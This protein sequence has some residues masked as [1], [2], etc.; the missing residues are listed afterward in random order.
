MNM[1]IPGSQGGQIGAGCLEAPIACFEA[2]LE[3]LDG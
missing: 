1:G 3:A 2:A